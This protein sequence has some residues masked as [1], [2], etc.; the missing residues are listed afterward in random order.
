MVNPSTSVY[1]AMEL[2]ILQLTLSQY[3][4]DYTLF[5]K[6]NH[7]FNTVFHSSDNNSNHLC[8]YP[9]KCEESYVIFTSFTVIFEI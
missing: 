2:E 6:R 1:S 5:E 7:P 9:F 3:F 4:G 8:L